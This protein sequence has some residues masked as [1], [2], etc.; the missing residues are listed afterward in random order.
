MSEKRH[1]IFL[2][3]LVRGRGHWAD[4]PQKFQMKFP[5]D[6]YEMIDLPGNGE[7]FRETSPKKM[8]D[9]VQVVRSRSVAIR[10]G[11]KVHL[12]ALSLGGM[13]AVDWMNHYGD[14]IEKTF[15]VCTS[16]ANM[17]HFYERFRPENYL[18]LL[19]LVKVHTASEYEEKLL[20]IIANNRD[21]RQDLLSQ[22]VH[23][24]ARYPMSRK[25]FLRQIFAASK[26][27]F[28]E[29]KP[30]VKEKLPLFVPV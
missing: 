16:A 1:W 22:L 26:A 23:Y 5:Q 28:P 21:R 8:L 19:S 18:K 10:E 6:T 2:R 25:N 20:D 24:S 15:L 11:K 12:L 3:G 14:E 9:Y 7:R 13:V 4:F 17:A 29:G 27:R 30:E